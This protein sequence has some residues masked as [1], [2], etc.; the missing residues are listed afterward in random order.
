MHVSKSDPRLLH[1][2]SVADVEPVTLTSLAAFVQWVA[3]QTERLSVA[4]E[5]AALTKV[6]YVT[7]PGSVVRV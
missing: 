1:E 2:L 7:C 5:K 3:W 4:N 6:P